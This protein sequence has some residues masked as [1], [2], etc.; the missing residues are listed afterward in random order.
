MCVTRP[1][2]MRLRVSLEEMADSRERTEQSVP[3]R[4]NSAVLRPVDQVGA[5]VSHRKK[6]DSK[7]ANLTQGH[8]PER[9]LGNDT[10]ATE[11]G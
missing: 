2:V 6:R 7:T 1:Y 4:Q 10:H 3:Y 11:N 9:I 8:G 5:D